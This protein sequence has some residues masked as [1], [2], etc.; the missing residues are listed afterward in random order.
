MNV[1]VKLMGVWLVPLFGFASL[2][3]AAAT[4]YR[5]VD[6]NGV[7]S[8]SDTRPEGALEVDTLQI[9]AQDPQLTQQDLDR[10][11][12]MRETTDRMAEDRRAREKHRAELRQLQS[13]S[14]AQQTY[15]QPFEGESSDYSSGYS[16]TSY[17]GGYYGYPTRPWR[18]GRPQRPHYPLRPD[19]KPRP[20]HPIARPPLRH[21]QQ[22]VSH[23]NRGANSQLMRP[24]VS[25]RR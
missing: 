6:D 9:D 25:P 5:T 14:R 3:V 11:E 23:I 1:A 12:D 8:F 20:E 4:V 15:Q 2:P 18:P 16:G 19:Y 24:I 7:V 13:A 21:P 22:A 10:L 17:W